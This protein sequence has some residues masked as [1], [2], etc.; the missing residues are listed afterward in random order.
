[1]KRTLKKRANFA[2]AVEKTQANIKRCVDRELWSMA[3]F[4]GHKTPLRVKKTTLV[5]RLCAIAPDVHRKFDL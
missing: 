5:E 2:A 4:F 3:Y 1:M